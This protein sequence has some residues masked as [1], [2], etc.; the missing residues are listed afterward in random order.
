MEGRVRDMEREYRRA[1]DLAQR[2][3]DQACRAA[4]TDPTVVAHRQHAARVRRQ[5]RRLQLRIERAVEECVAPP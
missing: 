1:A 3:Y 2:T 4:R 5:V